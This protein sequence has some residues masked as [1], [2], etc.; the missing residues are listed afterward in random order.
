MI[1]FFVAVTLLLETIPLAARTRAVAQPAGIPSPRSVLWVAA[2]PDD[3]AVAAP[4]LAEWCREQHARCTFLILTRGQAGAC[5]RAEGCLPDIAT[6][7]SAEAGAAAQY[8]DA[9]LIL[10]SL[11]DGGGS[12]APAWASGPLR[13]DVVSTVGAYIRAV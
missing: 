8:F 12:S 6:V 5:L 7:R 1:R 3:E 2:H 4:L 10:L 9:D 13:L 11:S